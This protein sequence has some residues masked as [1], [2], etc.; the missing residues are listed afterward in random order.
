MATYTVRGTSHNIVYALKMKDGKSKQHWESYTTELEALQRK[1]VIDNLQKNKQFEELK[2]VALEYRRKRAIEKANREAVAVNI[3]TTDASDEKPFAED[4]TNKTYYD[5]Q[6]KWLPIHARKKRFSPNSYDSYVGCLKNHILPYFGHRV[7]STITAEEID[8]FVDFLSKKPCKGNKSFRK[9]PGDIP[10]LASGTVKKCYTVLTAGFPLAKKWGYITNIPATTPPIEKTKKRRAWQPN[11][12]YE[13][14]EEIES[15]KMLHLAVHIAFV[16]SLRAGETVGIAIDSIDFHDRS[17]W[18]TQE[19]QRVSDKS[20]SELPSNE[21]L[22]VFPKMIPTAKSSIILKGP[23]TE[24]STRKN[25]LTTPLLIEI[26][27]RIA[28]IESNKEFFGEEYRDYGLLIC[29]PDGRPVDPKSLDGPFKKWQ[30]ALGIKPEDQIEFQ[31]LR[32]SGQMHKVRLSKNNYQ[33]VAENSGQSP[34][35]LMSN[36]ND[37]LESE[38]R[39]LSMMVETSFYPRE[40]PEGD[41]VATT[42]MKQIQGN[43]ELSAQILQMLLSNA[44]SAQQS[45]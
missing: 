2:K 33:L 41:H 28:Q 4:N 35:V 45:V 29:Q 22:R 1:I 10:T 24:G 44:V 43:P 23:K 38:K 12:I 16:C 11:R 14:L 18:I 8:E 25:Y 26:K 30:N 32:K 31:G 20:L 34:E 13:F 39:T 6:G 9:N 5:F 17:M 21:I 27:E 37:V 36:Y 42:V 7:M 15:D 19:V 40:M 3:G